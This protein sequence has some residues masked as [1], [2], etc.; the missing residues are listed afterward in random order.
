MAAEHSVSDFAVVGIPWG[1]QHY[2]GSDVRPFAVFWEVLPN[3]SFPSVF[4]ALD[5]AGDHGHDAHHLDA[6][7][8]G[9]AFS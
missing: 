7:R 3:L 8:Y 5:L 9:H 1:V 2:H 6:A 4:S